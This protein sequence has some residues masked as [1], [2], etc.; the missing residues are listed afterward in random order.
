[1]VNILIYVINGKPHYLHKDRLPK[2]NYILVGPHRT[3]F[4]PIYFA[5]GAWPKRFSFMAKKELFENPVLRLILNH[6]N[7]FSVDRQNPGPSAIKTPVNILRKTDLSLVLFPSGTRHSEELKGGAVLIARL[8]KVPLVPTVYQGP[9]TFKSLFD[10]KQVTVAF[11]E[12]IYVDSKKRLTDDQQAQLEKD[13]QSA[14][15][16]LDYS[17]DPT[18][19]Y[20]DVSKKS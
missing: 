9:L 14:F 7:A 2:G 13:M 1:M 6:V 20:V 18:F 3:W 11:G 10:R 5:L 8:A 15:D 12:P 4:D 19:K 17:V 16:A